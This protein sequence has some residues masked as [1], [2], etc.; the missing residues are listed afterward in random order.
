MSLLTSLKRILEGISVKDLKTFLRPAREAALVLVKA[1]IQNLF[2]RGCH[3]I[4]FNIL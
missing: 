4:I 2:L 3:F 1:D